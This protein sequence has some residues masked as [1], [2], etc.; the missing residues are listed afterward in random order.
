MDYD[1]NGL[2]P[3]DFEHLVQALGIKA[4]A[5]G[6]TPFGDGPEGA[7]EASYNGK[8]AYPS[9]ADPWNGYLVVQAKFLKKP[10]GIPAK[11]GAWV[12]KQLK[13]DLAKL[14]DKERNLTQP[15]YYVLATNV[16][17]TPVSETGSKDRVTTT[18]EEFKGKGLKAFDI[19]DYDKICRL[20]DG[21]PVIYRHYAGFITAGDVLTKVMTVLEEQLPNFGDVMSLFLQKEL[22]HDQFVKLE[23]AGHTLDQK[24]SLA[25]VFVDLPASDHPIS[26]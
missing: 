2:N 14:A 26:Q 19:R 24:T 7:R 23:Q 9:A 10:T 21:Y 17:L 4:I 11:D 20:L 12:L 13:S 22:R 16:T 5:A 18:L 6:L 15:D 3:R 25:N 8:M 1:L